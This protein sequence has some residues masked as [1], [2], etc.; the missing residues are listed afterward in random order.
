MQRTEQRQWVSVWKKQDR[1]SRSYMASRSTKLGVPFTSAFLSFAALSL[2]VLNLRF[3][4]F[5]PFWPSLAEGLNFLPLRNCIMATLAYPECAYKAWRKRLSVGH[6]NNKLTRTCLSLRRVASGR[7]WVS[8]K[9]GNWKWE[10]WCRSWMI[11]SVAIQSRLMWVIFST[12]TSGRWRSMVCWPLCT[13]GQHH[14]RIRTL[15]FLN[16][17]IDS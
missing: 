16:A 5:V 10:K 3:S 14:F 1:H 7:S 11:T 8:L 6:M 12:T 9:I 13:T 15:S 17:H 4:T 2:L